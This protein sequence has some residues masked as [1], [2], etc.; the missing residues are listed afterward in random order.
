M[1]GP[2]VNSLTQSTTIKQ[3]TS[4]LTNVEISCGVF[5]SFKEE[6]FE[7][8][9][10]CSAQENVGDSIEY[11]YEMPDLHRQMSKYS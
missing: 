3:S 5:N 7:L 1:K 11:Y 9:V 2:V 10:Q 8:T 4:E 6:E